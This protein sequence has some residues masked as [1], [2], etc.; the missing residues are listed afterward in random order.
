MPLNQLDFVFQKSQY[1]TIN[2]FSQE[3]LNKA[4]IYLLL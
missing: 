3:I 1:F 2:L 4:E